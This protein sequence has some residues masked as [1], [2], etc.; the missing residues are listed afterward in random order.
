MLISS[1]LSA[2]G[3]S[4]A[5]SVVFC[6]ARRAMS[7]SSA[8]VIPATQKRA[9]AHPSSSVDDQDHERRNQQHPQQR[10]LIRE[11]QPAMLIVRSPRGQ[12]GQ[13]FQTRHGVQRLGTGHEPRRLE[14]AVRRHVE[15]AGREAR[16][17][18]AGYAGCDGGKSTAARRAGPALCARSAPGDDQI[19]DAVRPH[20]ARSTR[21]TAL[22]GWNV[23]FGNGSITPARSDGQDPGRRPVRLRMS[24]TSGGV[25]RR[26]RRSSADR[27][28][29]TSAARSPRVT[30]A[31]RRNR[32]DTR[33]GSFAR[34]AMLAHRRKLVLDVARRFGRLGRLICADRRVEI[35]LEFGKARPEHMREPVVGS[36]EQPCALQVP[37]ASR[38]LAGLPLDDC[39]T[40]GAGRALS[41]DATSACP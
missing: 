15:D 17:D 19:E 32:A 13:S 12:T 3:S 40:R 38:R 35:A 21:R 11:R 18:V 23:W 24:V 4:Q 25:P 29:P 14:R 28:T 36:I 37:A 30:R 27:R 2:I 16:L 9:S 33:P 20:A 1:S 31:K 10:Q 41:G 6:P 39:Q 26:R 5:P 34:S 8:S 22:R 7:P